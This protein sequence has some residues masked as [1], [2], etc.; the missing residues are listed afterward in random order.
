MNKI[1]LRTQFFF[2]AFVICL[3]SMKGKILCNE[4][5]V[6]IVFPVFNRSLESARY[7]KQF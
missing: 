5:A 6:V 4:C 2:V 3:P 1:I 7:V